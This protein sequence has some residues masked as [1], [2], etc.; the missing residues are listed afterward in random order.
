MQISWSFIDVSHSTCFRHHYAHHQEYRIG[1]QTVYTAIN[2]TRDRPHLLKSTNARPVQ[3]TVCGLSAFPVL[4]MIGIMMP[5][6][7][8]VTNIN[9]TS[10]YLHLVSSF[11]SFTRNLVTYT[12]IVVWIVVCSK[13]HYQQFL[14]R[15]EAWK[16]G[17]VS[18]VPYDCEVS[19]VTAFHHRN[20]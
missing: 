16:K 5:E 9:K 18:R 14:L 15:K 19:A 20:A 4:L 17:T 6:T 7:W 3:N 2:C 13:W 8:W 11:F 12:Y 1:R 10:T